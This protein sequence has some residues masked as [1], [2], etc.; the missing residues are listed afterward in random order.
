MAVRSM[1]QVAAGVLAGAV[2]VGVPTWA[3]ASGPGDAPSPKKES[4]QAAMTSMMSMMPMMM[5]DPKMTAQMRS[6]M[7]DAKAKMSDMSRE[8]PS[9]KSSD[10]G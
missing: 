7:E 4:H 5:D 8:M 9:D 2:L 10:Q 6:M 3:F 1:V